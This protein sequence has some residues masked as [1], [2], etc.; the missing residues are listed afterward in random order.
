VPV[1]EVECDCN[2]LAAKIGQ[3]GDRVG[4]GPPGLADHVLA[5]ESQAGERFDIA[6]IASQRSQIP[7]LRL[8]DQIGPHIAAKRGGTAGQTIV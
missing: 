3:G 8:D 5:G 4:V 7:A 2:R 1:R 6:G